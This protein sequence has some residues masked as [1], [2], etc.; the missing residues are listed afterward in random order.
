M[1]ENK[2]KKYHSTGIMNRLRDKMPIIIIFLILAFVATIIFEWGMNYLGIKGGDITVFGKVNG[3]EITYEQ[4]E[5]L[6]QQQIEAMRQQSGGKDID[7]N[8]LTQLR[9]QV[10]NNLVQQ[11]LTKHEIERLGIKVTDAEIL[12][13]IYNRP[14]QLPDVI[15]R[16]F[17]DSTGVF[18]MEFYQQALQMKTQEATT[19]WNEVER[20]MREVLLAEKLQTIITASVNVSEY[21]VLQ[22][23]KDDNL[24]ANFN[25][26]FLDINSVL[27]TNALAVSEDELKK[28]YDEHKDEFKQNEAVRF[29]YVI[30]ND[31]ATAED[32]AAALKTMQIVKRDMKDAKL[33]DSTLIKLVNDYSTQPYSDAFQKPNAFGKK[34]L[35]FLF[36]AKIGDISDVLIDDDAYKVIKLIDTKD[37][38]DYFVSASHILINFGTD[39]AGARRRAEDI[40]NRV[41]KG[42]DF[43]TLAQQ[44]SED[45]S[46]Q[47]NNGDM[48][49]FGKGTMVKEFEDACYNA[50]VGDIVGP[51]KT[52]YGF[53][54]IKV[55]GRSKREFRVAEVRKPV[56]AS[57][58]T[59]DIIRRNAMDFIATVEDGAIFDSLAKQVKVAVFGTPEI[60]ED[61]FVPGAGQNKNLINFGLKN[62]TGKM[63]GPIKMQGGFGVYQIIQKIPEGYK[64]YDSVKTTLVKP[65]LV[66]LKKY[67]YLKKV[68]NEM[69]SKIMGNDLMGLQYAYPQYKFGTGDSVCVSK[70]DP[71]IGLE[72]PVFYALYSLKPGE[73]SNPVV[74]LRGVYLLKLNWITQFDQNDYL[75]KQDKLRKDL[76]TVK[77]QS[78]VQEWLNNLVNNAE[79]IDNRDKFF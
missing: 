63:Y 47:Q 65:K 15:K 51:V 50:A 9:E 52:Q 7:E 79:I 58:R 66:Q 17:M 24:K 53:H 5:A 74:G 41:K 64:N 76:L 67:Q 12:D 42:E 16:N 54:I 78:A 70:P 43:S 23:Y 11:T 10:W 6:L 26:A 13:W 48:G 69:K 2:P 35:N 29:R 62:K 28:Y 44:L 3:E 73:V 68:A 14:E 49:W 33:E 40:Y 75:A 25:F 71:Q 31:A 39:T 19:F 61:G 37:G 57:Q 21:D 38:E 45:P 77:K 32:S 8:M 55:N 36:N 18:N 20:Y 22:K 4:Y 30:F 46:V 60:E 72:Y 27:D 56:T 34:A 1:A 59:K